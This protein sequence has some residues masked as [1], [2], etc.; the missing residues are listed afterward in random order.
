MLPEDTPLRTDLFNLFSHDEKRKRLDAHLKNRIQ[1]LTIMQHQ[2]D[3]IMVKAYLRA[4]NIVIFKHTV[5]DFMDHW[6]IIRGLLTFSAID[7]DFEWVLTR[8]DELGPDH[9]LNQELRADSFY[10]YKLPKIEL[11]MNAKCRFA[12]TRKQQ[13]SILVEFLS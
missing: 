7:E 11:M 10:N 8:R 5:Q 12:F 1:Q 6:C 9:W 2:S 3:S 13:K 4:I